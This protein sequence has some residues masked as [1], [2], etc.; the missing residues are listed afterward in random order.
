MLVPVRAWPEYLELG[1][2]EI[3]RYGASSVQ[4]VRRL[5]A[6]LEELHGAVGPERQAAVEE[7]LARLDADVEQAFGGSTDLDRAREPDRQGIGGASR[8][9]G[10]GA[11][12][13]HTGLIGRRAPSRG[14]AS[15]G[16]N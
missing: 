16:P 2:T 8:A 4:V 11:E 3:R 9:R 15:A 12:R 6:M 5:R 14:S 10:S 1:V 7:E 13:D